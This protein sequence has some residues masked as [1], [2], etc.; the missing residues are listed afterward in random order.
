[1]KIHRTHGIAIIL[2]AAIVAASA[3][4]RRVV[5]AAL[6]PAPDGVWTGI[7]SWYGPGFDGKT[8]SNGD[9]YDMRAMTAAHKTLPFDTLVRVTNL[10]NGKSA[11]VRI[12]DRGPFVEGR[13]IDLSQ[14]AA[15]AV[16][17][18]EP[19]TVPVRLEPLAGVSFSADSPRWAVQV[20]SFISAENARSLKSRLKPRFESVDVF[21]SAVDGQTYFRVRISASDRTAAWALVATLARDGIGAFIVEGR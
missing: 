19:G 21:R 10:T 12:N 17:M 5:P 16:D 1:M 14:A 6:T 4:V 15:E 9:V 2:L 8:T 13:I 20:G 11:V 3:C 18:I 7:A